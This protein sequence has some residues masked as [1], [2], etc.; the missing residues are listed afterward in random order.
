M[1]MNALMYFLKGPAFIYAGQEHEISVAPSLFENDLVPWD[2]TNSIESFFKRLSALKK[3]PI[4]IHGNYNLHHSADVAVMSYTYQNQY[5]VG[6]FNLENA[7]RV[8]VPLIDGNYTNF[9]NDED[10]IVENGKIELDNRPI[11]I[12]TLKEHKK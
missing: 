2:R 11:I 3:Q 8:S 10:I 1:Q 6:I 4:F 12:D 5:L 9:I 7:N